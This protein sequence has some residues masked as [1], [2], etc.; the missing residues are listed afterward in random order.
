[1]PRKK[2]AKAPVVETPVETK[3]RR[4]YPE[5]KERIAMAE[6]DI[7]RLEALN[8]ARRALIARSE[9]KLNERKAALARTEAQLAREVSKRD[10]LIALEE[11]PT[12]AARARR[13]AE[14][15]QM[16]ELAAALKASGKTLDEVLAALKG[17]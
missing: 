11:N 10:R 8:E 14:N 17:E 12:G 6:K 2:V 13:K 4:P 15:A 16:K 1:M 9:A 7:A 3:T 5:R